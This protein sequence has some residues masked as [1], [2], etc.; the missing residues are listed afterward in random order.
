MFIYNHKAHPSLWRNRLA[1]SAVNRKVGGSS[2]P[3]DDQFFVLYLYCICIVFENVIDITMLIYISIALTLVPS[4]QNFL[5]DKI[6]WPDSQK[7]CDS[8]GF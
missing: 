3:R 1:R 6:Y 4:G 2:L 5:T 7:N 8:I